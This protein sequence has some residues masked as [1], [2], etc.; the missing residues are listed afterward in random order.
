MMKAKLLVE[1]DTMLSPHFLDFDDYILMY[2]MPQI[3]PTVLTTPRWFPYGV[4][5]EWMDS[6][7]SIWNSV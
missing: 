7:D 1:I 2:F 5:M 4:H 3:V 6:M